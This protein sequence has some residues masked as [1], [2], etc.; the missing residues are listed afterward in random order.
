MPLSS[1]VERS[2]DTFIDLLHLEVKGAVSSKCLKSIALQHSMMCQ[3]TLSLQLS[4][5]TVWT[6]GTV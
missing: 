5:E 3:E 1:V 4:V 2:G 6:S